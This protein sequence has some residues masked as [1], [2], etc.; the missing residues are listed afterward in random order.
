MKKFFSLILLFLVSFSHSFAE[1]WALVEPNL[2]L[3]SGTVL[4]VNS[5]T[6]WTWENVLVKPVE[7]SIYTYYYSVTCPYCQK[8]NRYLDSVDWYSKLNIDKREVLNNKDNSM[9][10]AE[11]IQ[12]LGLENQNI[13]VPFIIVNNWWK[14]THL[15]GLDQA[16]AY[17]EPILWKYD[18]SEI[19]QKI[20]AEQEQNKQ[21][22]KENNK[23]QKGIFIIILILLAIIIPTVIILKK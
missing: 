15:T 11:D 13:W 18:E 21:I 7:S 3:S 14:E 4:E 16:I 6:T 20:K 10:M 1:S 17:L 2:N 5:A 9:K 19:N 23:E 8:L 22:M 12:R